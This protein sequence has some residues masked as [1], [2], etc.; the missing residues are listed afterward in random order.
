MTGIQLKN[1]P[2][3]TKTRAGFYGMVVFTSMT[4]ISCITSIMINKSLRGNVD[5]ILLSVIGH[6]A[7]WRIIYIRQDRP[8]LSYFDG[9]Y[10]LLK[11]CIAYLFKNS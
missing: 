11:D 10:V 4:V 7:L 8:E 5:D 6:T 1:H 9:A 3:P 2:Y